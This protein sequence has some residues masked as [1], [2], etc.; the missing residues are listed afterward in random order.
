MTLTLIKR[1]IKD[2]LILFIFRPILFIFC[3]VSLIGKLTLVLDQSYLYF[4]EFITTLVVSSIT[5]SF[6]ILIPLSRLSVLILFVI[7]S[8]VLKIYIKNRIIRFY[9]KVRLYFPCWVFNSSVKYD[10]IIE[11]LTK[12]ITRLVNVFIR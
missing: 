6:M 5:S 2:K 7:S 12:F 4:H 8:F 10:L 9:F 1:F 11:Y 3:E